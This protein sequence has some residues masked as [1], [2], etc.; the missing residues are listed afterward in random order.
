MAINIMDEISLVLSKAFPKVNIYTDDQEAGFKRP[1]FAVYI[2][3]LYSNKQLVGRTMR[4]YLVIIKYYPPKAKAGD[5]FADEGRSQSYQMLEDWEDF[6]FDNPFDFLVWNRRATITNDN[7]LNIKF[8]AK[9]R[10]LRVPDEGEEDF[11]YMKYL[12]KE[13]RIRYGKRKGS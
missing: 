5:S 2:P 4:N 8:N 1:A 7:T 3:N 13:V 6:M 10:A 11:E 12:R 9:F